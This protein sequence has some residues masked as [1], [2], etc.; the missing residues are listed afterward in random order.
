MIYIRIASPP[1]IQTPHFNLQVES[2][3]CCLMCVYV[4]ALFYLPWDIWPTSSSMNSCDRSTVTKY[5]NCFTNPNKNNAH[6]QQILTVY[7]WCGLLFLIA[8]NSAE[9]IWAPATVTRKNND[10]LHFFW[11]DKDLLTFPIMFY[12]QKCDMFPFIIGMNYLTQLYT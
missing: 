3:L 2:L 1:I 7:V 11:S 9:L 6:F 8:K 4:Q 10:D 12:L 5:Q